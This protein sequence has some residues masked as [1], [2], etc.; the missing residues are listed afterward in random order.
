[1]IKVIIITEATTKI[2]NV[3]EIKLCLFEPISLANWVI[4][5]DVK[6]SLQFKFAI[7]KAEST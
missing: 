2:A 1:M 7:S 5:F 3:A 6:L 4:I